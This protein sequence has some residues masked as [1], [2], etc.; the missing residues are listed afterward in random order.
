[1]HGQNHIKFEGNIP[2]V[3]I[4]VNQGLFN[5]FFGLGLHGVEWYDNSDKNELE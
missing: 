3:S 1:M 2:S 4:H 5:I